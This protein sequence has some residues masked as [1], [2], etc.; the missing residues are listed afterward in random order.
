MGDRSLYDRTYM[1][2][3]GSMHSS[4]ITTVAGSARVMLSKE[5]L[6]H[7]GARPWKSPD[8]LRLRLRTSTALAEDTMPDDRKV[9]R[10][11]AQ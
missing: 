11:L 10:I 2:E 6:A 5:V 3:G 9:L 7:R 1:D 8:A 4:K